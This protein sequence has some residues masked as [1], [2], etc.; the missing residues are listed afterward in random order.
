MIVIVRSKPVDSED[1]KLSRSASLERAKGNC[2][3]LK[4]VQVSCGDVHTLALTSHGEVWSWGTGSQTGHGSNEIV[5]TPQLVEGLFGRKVISI[6]CGAYHSIALVKDPSTVPRIVPHKT[7]KVMRGSEKKRSK[8]LR[9]FSRSKESSKG[10]KAQS[11]WQ[12]SEGFSASS[13]I[14]RNSTPPTPP[15][16][17][18]SYESEASSQ[19]GVNEF[20]KEEPLMKTNE[21]E[22]PKFDETHNQ[23]ELQHLSNPPPT[24]HNSTQ[25]GNNEESDEHS[26][27]PTTNA[28]TSLIQQKQLTEAENTITSEV[29]PEPSTEVLPTPY[30]ESELKASL[31]HEETNISPV[32]P[33]GQNYDGQRRVSD[34]IPINRLSIHDNHYGIPAHTK[35]TYLESLI[36]S[37]PEFSPPQTGFHH[38]H[39]ENHSQ[40]HFVATDVSGRL[41]EN[42]SLFENVEPSSLTSL[43]SNSD[44]EEVTTPTTEEKPNSMSA[45][46]G[47]GILTSR[48]RQE[49]D[50]TKLTTA[51]YDSVTGMFMSP[52]SNT[53]PVVA[54]KSAVHG[55][56]CSECGVLGICVCNNK[57]FSPDKFIHEGYDTQVWTW[58]SGGCGQLGHGD[59]DDR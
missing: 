1:V 37:S 2:V 29:P 25:N 19:T 30:Q 44:S 21:A 40:D 50:F 23:I 46:L 5:Q 32:K 43:Y 57:V 58:G 15:K 56:H 38:S 14:R 10:K 33:H 47:F 51:V 17:Y 28:S 45:Y 48:L 26:T 11:L 22:L 53:L 35:K 20:S 49:I 12:G 3:T 41:R 6:E 42:T 9:R 36:S 7:N 8:K 52:S 31:S 59:T 18:L 34:S 4:I 39:F 54:D 13:E 16:T 55:A 24:D 27:I